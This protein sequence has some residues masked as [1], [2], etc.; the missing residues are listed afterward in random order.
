MKPP[1]QPATVALQFE[2]RFVPLILN[3]TKRQTLRKTR[4]CRPGDAMVLQDTANKTFATVQCSAVLPV[5]IYRFGVYQDGVSV[6]LTEF[7][8]AE[9]FASWWDQQDWLDQHNQTIPARGALERWCHR[10]NVKGEAQT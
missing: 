3:G 10:W 2:D 9:G 7:A 5:R 6:P 8:K 1:I 4:H